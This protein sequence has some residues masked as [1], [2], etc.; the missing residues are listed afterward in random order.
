MEDLWVKADENLIGDDH[1]K[2]DEFGEMD[3]GQEEGRTN[4]RVEVCG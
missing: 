2:W 1:L 3:I 4:N